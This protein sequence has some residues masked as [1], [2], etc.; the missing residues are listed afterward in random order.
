MYESVSYRYVN[1]ERGNTV[2]FKNLSFPKGIPLLD[3]P[4]MYSRFYYYYMN[5]KKSEELFPLI[6]PLNR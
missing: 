5:I 4:I 2:K 3:T 6:L 1:D